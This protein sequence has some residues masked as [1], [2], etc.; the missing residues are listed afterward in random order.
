M[1]IAIKQEITTSFRKS[2][3]SMFQTLNVDA[4]KTFR[5]PI[6]LVRCS[7]TKE[8]SPKRPRQLIKIAK[9]VKIPD[10]VPIRSSAANFSP[11]SLS[12]KSY[13]NGM[14]GK[15][16][17]EYP[18][19]NCQVLACTLIRIQPQIIVARI[20][21]PIKNIESLLYRLIGRLCNHVFHH[22]YYL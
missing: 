17:L 6:S 22:A 7:A 18:F 3:D 13:S 8:V 12:T 5:T 2:F 14:S 1:G 11:Y 9:A 21:E 10:K 16:L 19:Y 4:P 15:M 20:I